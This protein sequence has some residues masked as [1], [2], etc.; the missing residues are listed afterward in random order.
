MSL[1]NSILRLARSPHGRRLAEQA[2]R[3][4]RDPKTRQQLEQVRRRVQGGRS[5]R[6]R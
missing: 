4:A 2:V 6:P 3:A 5:G 1:M